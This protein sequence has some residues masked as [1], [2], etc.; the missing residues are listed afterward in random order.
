LQSGI[1]DSSD[2]CNKLLNNENL[3]PYEIIPVLDEEHQKYVFI[4]Q[5]IIVQSAE[6]L[7]AIENLNEGLETSSVS[8]PTLNVDG[9]MEQG[10]SA[11][12]SDSS[13]DEGDSG[14]SFNGA[15]DEGEVGEMLAADQLD[16]ECLR[17]EQDAAECLAIDRELTSALACD[18][19]MLALLETSEHFDE[20]VDIRNEDYNYEGLESHEEVPVTESDFLHLNNQDMFL[21]SACIIH[22]SS[23]SSQ[24]TVHSMSQSQPPDL[25]TSFESEVLTITSDSLTGDGHSPEHQSTGFVADVSL[26]S[27][28]QC[29]AC[30]VSSNINDR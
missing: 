6:K 2:H 5:D 11:G 7:P 23:S 9:S 25:I 19:E 22:E 17:T 21:S 18:E 12:D 15:F 10:S 28:I 4:D 26:G 20:E 24:N 8:D 30:I 14:S 3:F 1:N 27:E 16:D 13:V 29:C